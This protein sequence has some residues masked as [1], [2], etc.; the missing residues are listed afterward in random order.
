[1]WD[2]KKVELRGL[3]TEFRFKM[4]SPEYKIKAVEPSCVSC[5]NVQFTD[6]SIVG[7][8]T[9]YKSE[10]VKEITLKVLLMTEDSKLKLDKLIIKAHSK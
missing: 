8:I 9:L 7:T 1:M 5:T 6:N 4:T 10:T 3:V 2:K